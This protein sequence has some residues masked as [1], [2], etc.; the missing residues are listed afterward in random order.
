MIVVA[1]SAPSRRSVVQIMI[2]IA[3]AAAT[4]SSVRV[5]IIVVV[6]VAAATAATVGRISIVVVA[7]AAATTSAATAVR[8]IAVVVA[9]AA[10]AAA[11][12]R[13]LTWRLIS[14][15]ATITALARGVVLVIAVRFKVPLRGRLAPAAGR[16][17]GPAVVAMSQGRRPTRRRWPAS[18]AAAASGCTGSPH[19]F[20][21]SFVARL[22]LAHL[23]RTP[24]AVSR[25]GQ[26]RH[27]L[28]ENVSRCGQRGRWPVRMLG[29][30]CCP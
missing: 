2:V 6:A 14:I 29:R 7:T 28:G 4:G 20:L 1:T 25:S 13:V 21:V 11:G 19:V 22:L 3:A 10:A 15:I 12:V 5:V 9:A 27:W 18:A 24:L 8:L 16:R 26:K 30:V 23:H 17:R